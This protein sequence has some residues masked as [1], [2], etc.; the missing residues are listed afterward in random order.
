MYPSPRSVDAGG[1]VDVSLQANPGMILLLAGASL[2]VTS[3]SRVAAKTDAPGADDIPVRA[4]RAVAQDVP[5]DIA[6]VGNV[7]SADS[8]EVKSRIAGQ[9]ERVAFQEGEN[10]AKGQLLFTIDR[11]ALERQAA[12]QRA[13]LARDAAIEQQE[14]AIVAR[15][16]AAQRQ[17]QSEADVAVQ[18][19]ILG[20]ISGQRVDELTTARDTASASLHSDEAAVVAAEAARKADQARLDA[21]ELQLSQ[22]NVV[23]PIAGRVGA[24]AVKAGNIAAENGTTLVTLLQMTPIDV[25][26]GVPEQVLTDVQQLKAHGT[27]TV[28]ASHGGGGSEEGRLSFIDNAVDATTGTIRLKAIFSN[29]DGALWPG[30]FV[31]VRLRLRVDASRTVIPSASVEDGINGK[32]VWL[33]RSGRASMTPVTVMRTYLPEQGPE[34]A[35]IG[36]GVRPGDLVVSEGQLR[37]TAAARVSLLNDGSGPGSSNPRKDLE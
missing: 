35:V 6:A 33:V 19:G 18:L 17:S 28:E 7:E 24:A 3:C 14:R 30:E 13:E 11:A 29:T 34:L 9:V 16:T 31:H 12:E 32:Y 27:L 20:V 5:L 15:D 4:V 1:E 23:A 10:V 21:T 37:L 22:T 8:V 36:S 2:A 25:A 26:F